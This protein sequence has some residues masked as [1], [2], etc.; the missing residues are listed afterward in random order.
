MN[1][2]RV[3]SCMHRHEFIHIWSLVVDSTTNLARG[4]PTK[5]ST[6]EILTRGGA[7]KAVDGNSNSDFTAS[8]CTETRESTGSWWQVDLGSVY[9]IRDVV[10]TNRGDCCCKFHVVCLL[11]T[12][13][14][15]R[16]HAHT[17]ARTHARTHMYIYIYIYIYIN[18]N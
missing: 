13:T 8:S 4:K 2:A 1:D 12:R 3:Y 7:S 14:Y 17:H 15:T 11:H 9:G 5:Q 6:T 16:T 18:I 10:I